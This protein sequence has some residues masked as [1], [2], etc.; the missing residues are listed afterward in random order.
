VL[1]VQH[2]QQAIQVLCTGY[3]QEAFWS[4][5]ECQVTS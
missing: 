2:S 5:P 1:L 4:K 3:R